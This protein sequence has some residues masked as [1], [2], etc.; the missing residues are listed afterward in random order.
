MFIIFA[1]FKKLEYSCFTMLCFC[2]TTKWI[3]YVYTHTP[4]LVDLTPGSPSHPPR[5]PQ[6]TQLSSLCYTVASHWLSLSYSTQM[7]ILVSQFIPPFSC[8]MTSQVHSPSLCLYSCPANRF[9]CTI[10]LDSFSRYL[11][12]SFGLTSLCMTVS[13]S[14][15][16]TSLQMTQC[17]SFL[18][19]S[20]G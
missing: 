3:T 14:G 18:W 13:R 15:S 19:L 17:H 9:I 11:F 16:C 6:G 2:G 10:F 7:S 1:N 5:S 8:C 12:F 4:S 20:N